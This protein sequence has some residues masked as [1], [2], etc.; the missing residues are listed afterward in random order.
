M[1]DEYINAAGNDVTA[2]WIAYVAPLVGELPV[3]GRL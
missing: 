2:A 3:I 1:R